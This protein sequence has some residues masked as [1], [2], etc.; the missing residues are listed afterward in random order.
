MITMGRALGYLVLLV[1]YV[2]VVAVFDPK[3]PLL[4]LDVLPLEVLGRCEEKE[5][6]SL[7]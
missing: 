4:P 6:L 5:R 3:R 2:G 1:S 7:E